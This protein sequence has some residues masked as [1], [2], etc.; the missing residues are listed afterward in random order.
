MLA[1]FCQLAL[2]CA[3][4]SGVIFT[5]Q[6]L[7]QLRRSPSEAEGISQRLV[8]LTTINLTLIF[9]SFVGLIILF[10]NSDFSV[11]NVAENSNILLPT[12]YKVAASWGSHEGSLQ[13]WIVMLS[14]WSTAFAYTGRALPQSF[15]AN[16][17]GCLLVIQS[18]FLLYLLTA[19]NPF[20]RILPA[21]LSGRDL[22]P[23]LQDFFMVIHPP[24]LYMGYVGFAVCFAIAIAALIERRF[25]SDWARMSRPWANAAWA[26][27]TIGI[28]LGSWWA[29]R[30]LG[31]G[32]WWFWDP[33]ENAS[34]M[35]WFVG[36]ALIH[37]LAASDKRGAFKNWTILLA[38][39]AFALS[40]LG[41]FLVRSGVLTSVH[42]FATDPA[43]G[44]FILILLGVIVGAALVLYA[45]RAHLIT[46]GTAFRALSK[47]TLILTNNLLMT[48]ALGVIFLGT[49]YPLFAEL[50]TGKK[51]SV[52]PP[53]F[54]A[55]VTP[56]LLPAVL[57]MAL[58]P[59]L[60]WRQ[61]AVGQ[62]VQSLLLPSLIAAAAA[63]AFLLMFDRFGVLAALGVFSAIVL[64]LATVSHSVSQLKKL[65]DAAIRSRQPESMPLGR[66]MR[67]LGIAYWAMIVAHLGIAIFA[68]GVTFA[69]SLEVEKEVI[70]KPGE[71]VAFSGW[72]V[73][74][75][76]VDD[77]R[78]P[79]YV[80]AAG[81]FE[82]SEG[83]GHRIELLEP[84][85]RRYLSGDQVLT[86]AAV[87]YGW[88]GDVYLSLGDPVSGAAGP[89][90]D[91]S[92]SVRIFYKPMM[93]WIWIGCGLM[94]SGGVLSLFSRRI[95]SRSRA[96]DEHGVA[97][98]ATATP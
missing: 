23:L 36:T 5:T 84:Q 28:A 25:D 75:V 48:M 30:E 51:M 33:V 40:L 12:A 58:A 24:F 57:L 42:A 62:V 7:I 38:I 69:K 95:R 86:E 85:K 29:Y 76:G 98:G 49:L 70:L 63:I 26:S 1:E 55:V 44:V 10:L 82:L 46:P 13:L 47:E 60:E 43:R 92:W 16:V 64:L 71:T 22:N 56:F 3:F 66:R 4:V 79:N 6:L 31:W 59:R 14:G 45:T 96:Q 65:K 37:S 87:R 94:A 52:G 78:G 81:V 19:S 91:G 27:L 2:I 34:L 54:E 97:D 35:P 89:D 17:L 53:Y 50:V 72:S 8:A 39:L 80:A 18:A 61:A 67:Q 83:S 74:F 20:E 68:L 32:G 90:A 73:T 9:A 15:R 88:L 41:T 77:R 93:I 11:R 21:P